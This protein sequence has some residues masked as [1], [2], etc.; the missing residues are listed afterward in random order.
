MP[1][2]WAVRLESEGEGCAAV[3]APFT[4]LAQVCHTRTRETGLVW[5]IRRLKGRAANERPR[6]TLSRGRFVFAP[7]KKRRPHQ[8]K[9]LKLADRVGSLDL[10]RRILLPVADMRHTEPAVKVKLQRERYF[11]MAREAYKRYLD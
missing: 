3:H 4:L 7:N 8:D 1:P 6:R 10:S 9:G 2:R 11:L 5:K